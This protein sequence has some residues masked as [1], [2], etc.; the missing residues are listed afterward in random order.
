VPAS[1]PAA[2]RRSVRPDSELTRFLARL[3]A[4]A[5]VSHLSAP[6][7]VAGRYLD[8]VLREVHQRVVQ[9]PKDVFVDFHASDLRSSGSFVHHAPQHLLHGQIVRPHD[10]GMQVS[11]RVMRFAAR[12][13][14]SM[15]EPLGRFESPRPLG[16]RGRQTR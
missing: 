11:S 3:P 14:P 5:S 16:T 8:D 12:S 7:S 15:P 1:G 9:A 4:S 13:V 6:P 2:A 10:H